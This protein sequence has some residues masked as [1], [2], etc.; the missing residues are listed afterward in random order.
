MTAEGYGLPLGVLMKVLE[1]TVVVAQLCERP[2]NGPCGRAVARHSR[3]EPRWARAGTL[4]SGRPGLAEPGPHS[5]WTSSASASS[6]CT[7]GQDA[8][9]VPPGGRSPPPAADGSRPPQAKG[10]PLAR[11]CWA[12]SGVGVRTLPGPQEGRPLG[13]APPAQAAWAGSR[14]CP[15]SSL[16]TL[17]GPAHL[18]RFPSGAPPGPRPQVCGDGCGSSPQGN[19]MCCEDGPLL[20]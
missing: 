17:K 19:W 11:K 1:T 15:A 7:G 18:G 12:W 5:G 10:S 6:L 4:L 8:L 16:R 3:T 20:V 14:L 2:R 13:A 9:P